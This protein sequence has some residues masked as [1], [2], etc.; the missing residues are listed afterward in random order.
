MRS[1]HFLASG[2]SVGVGKLVRAGLG[3]SVGV[4]EI[5]VRVGVAWRYRWYFCCGYRCIDQ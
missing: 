4:I 3:V 5:G 2:V 1:G